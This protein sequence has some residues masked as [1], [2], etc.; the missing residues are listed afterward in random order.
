M[1]AGAYPYVQYD[2][3]A[4]FTAPYGVQADGEVKL[5][6]IDL[7]RHGEML[8]GLEITAKAIEA[9]QGADVD[10][11]RYAPHGSFDMVIMN[12]PF[13]RPTNHEGLHENVPNPMFAAFGSSAEDQKAMSDETKI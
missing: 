11:W 2:E 9:T 12:P 13:T 5:G 4:I 10:I 6:S 7:L 3:S 8:Q 1:L